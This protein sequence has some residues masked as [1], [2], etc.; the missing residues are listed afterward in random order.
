MQ[1]ITVYQDM[2]STKHTWCTLVFQLYLYPLR[3][4]SL[5]CV[6]CM[7][8]SQVLCTMYM[9]YVCTKYALVSIPAHVCVNMHSV[10]QYVRVSS[11]Y[12]V[13][14]SVCYICVCALFEQ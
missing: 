6:G 7:L 13:H 2:N 12:L 14:K 1:Y 3:I 10:N 11:V 9:Q 8:M 4:W 5:V